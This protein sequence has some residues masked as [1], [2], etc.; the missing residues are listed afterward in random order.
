MAELLR[1]LVRLGEKAA[2]LAR[3]IRAERALFELLVEEKKGE[4]KNKRFI[5]DFKTLA[6]VL[7][8][9]MIRYDVGN[10]FAGLKEFVFGEES[11]KFTNTSGE[12]ITVAVQPSVDETKNLLTKVLDGN[13][14]AASLLAQA[15]HAEANTELD[16]RLADLAF[17]LDIDNVG[18]WID[19]IDSTAEYIKGIEDEEAESGIYQHGL[20]C[21]VVLIGAFD[22]KTG[23]PLMGVINQPFAKQ[24]TDTKSWTSSCYWGVRCGDFHCNSLISSADAETAPPSENG[25]SL[26]MSSSED[27]HIKD[28]MTSI[29]TVHYASGAGYKILCV[30]AGLVDAYILSKGSTFKWDTCGPH[31]ILQSLGGG[32]VDY[33]KWKSAST[34]EAGN[35]QGISVR[36]EKPDVEGAVPEGQTWSNSGGIVCFRSESVL[37][38]IHAAVKK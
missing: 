21:A 35:V 26:I 1:T 20:Q 30:I 13:Q 34:E 14:V 10:Q 5:H 25:L 37:A 27:A 3:I 32:I 18:I 19:P 22:R 7:I 12:S 6:D 33:D 31:A 11:N 15:V 38:T 23:S 16:A 29:G 2:N 4:A 9:E 36:Y 8:Q 24:D 17:D 28:A